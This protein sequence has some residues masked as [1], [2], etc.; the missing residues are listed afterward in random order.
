MPTETIDKRE[1][2]LQL[3][4]PFAIGSLVEILV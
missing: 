4:K 3:T 1:Q 2:K